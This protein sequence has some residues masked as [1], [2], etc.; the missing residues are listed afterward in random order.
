MKTISTKLFIKEQK[1]KPGYA[2]I[3]LRIIYD[4]TKAE[5]STG[6]SCQIVEW[7]EKTE[8]CNNEVVQE[9]LF[10]LQMEVLR[11]KALLEAKEEMISAQR[12]KDRIQNRTGVKNDTELM[13]FLRLCLE[14]KRQ[15]KSCSESTLLKYYQ[16]LFYVEQFLRKINRFSLR[17]S[18]VNPAFI[19]EF[20]YFL[21]TVKWNA[22]SDFLKE[23]TR[24]KHHVRLKA[25]L[26]LA[27]KQAKIRNNPYENRKLRFPTQQRSYLSLPELKRIEK[28]DFSNNPSLQKV[29]L[30]FLFS[31]YTGIRFSDGQILSVT[32]IIEENGE[33]Y[34]RFTQGKTDHFLE[35]PVLEKARNILELIDKNR[36]VFR[37]NSGELLP[38][39]SNQ[40]CNHYLKFI[41]ELSGIRTNLSHHIARHTFATTVLLENEV[42]LEVV[43]HLLGHRSVKTTQIYAKITKGRLA[44]VSQSLNERLV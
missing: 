9:E 29:K 18:D 10:K 23:S 27:R 11:I 28:L 4:R 6:F 20:D 34:I 30:L 14:R 32:D 33:L 41:A 1:R 5:L 25:L 17:L 7:D 43:S 31:C 21:K 44:L 16:T 3:Y 42:P 36:S 35:I 24:N 12:I 40:K 19:D 13:E 39:I 22:N 38:K 26:D 2:R 15:D 8:K 37:M